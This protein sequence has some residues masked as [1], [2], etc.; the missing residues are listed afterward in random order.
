VISAITAGSDLLR[1]VSLRSGRRGGS[2]GPSLTYFG[3]SSFE[4]EIVEASELIFRIDS[5]AA[6][7][8]DEDLG[9]PVYTST[10]QM[11]IPDRSDVLARCRKHKKTNHGRKHESRDGH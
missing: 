7:W 3:T 8:A 6:G 1:H 2:H 5:H 4:T 11:R 9:H 10:R